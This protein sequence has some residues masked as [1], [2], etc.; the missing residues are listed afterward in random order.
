MRTQHA[1]SGLFLSASFLLPLLSADAAWLAAQLL[2]SL[3]PVHLALAAHLEAWAWRRWESSSGSTPS[4]PLPV[5]EVA[6]DTDT[7]TVD[8][9]RPFIVRGL[10]NSSAALTDGGAWLRT[11]SVGRLE[12]P[13]YSNA[14]NGA[15]RPD[16][17]GA[18]ADIVADIE[19][20]G[21]Q[22]LGTELVFRRH[23]ELLDQL[24][25]ATPLARLF[26]S[27]PFATWRIGKT[28][29]VPLFLG[30]GSTVGAAV[31]TD[32]HSEPIGSATLQLAGSKVWTLAPGSESRRLRP[33]VAADGRAFYR[34][35]RAHGADGRDALAA[36]GA[37]HFEVEQRPGDVLWVPTWT[38]HRVDYL[39][40]VT[41]LSVSL[42]HLRAE[43][44]AGLQP[45]L[46]VAVLPALFK[47][48][49]GWKT[50]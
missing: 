49:I 30:T 46:T 12:V 35:L 47:E 38:W 37:A 6:A 39:P 2:H 11:S 32:L 15:L 28:L 20:G 21:P 26:G 50:Q 34:T 48:L 22:K 23:P 5:P 44:L 14:S 36:S 31:R 3:C 43:Q 10:L 9:R 25:L 13:F 27:G 33:S 19:A 29:T 16:S 18:L 1:L 4:A 7:E 45:I 40:G 42:F 8:L 24:G 41:A 17:S